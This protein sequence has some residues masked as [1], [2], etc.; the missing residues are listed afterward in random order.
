MNCCNC[1]SQRAIQNSNLVAIQVPIA[2]C[3]LYQSDE[4]P[5]GVWVPEITWQQ[6][7]IDKGS[8]GPFGIMAQ[9]IADQAVAECE[10]RNTGLAKIAQRLG[11]DQFPISLPRSIKQ[12]PGGSIQMDI[13]SFPEMWLWWIKQFDSIVG[14]WPVEISIKDSDPLKA[15]EQPIELKNPNMAEAIAEIFGLTL[16]AEISAE[17]AVN[18]AFRTLAE[19][20]M[21]KNAAIV[22]QDLAKANELA[23]KEPDGIL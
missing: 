4:T 10:G 13:N 17:T 16:S 8:A 5:D 6:I 19:A 22:S 9:S 18:I 21:A 1:D 7:K 3:T 2:S 12:V 15:G 14:Q 23:A 20:G 11:V